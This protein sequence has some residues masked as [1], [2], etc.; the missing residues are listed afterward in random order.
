MS[1]VFRTSPPALHPAI[2]SSP[3]TKGTKGGGVHT[4]RPVRGWGGV[5]IFRKTPDIGLASNSIIPLR[6]KSSSYISEVLFSISTF[7]FQQFLVSFDRGGRGGRPTNG[8]RREKQTFFRIGWFVS[9]VI[10][11][12]YKA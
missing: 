1:G 5:S 2:V 7:L 10:C 12:K 11:T 9:I 3:R 4:H 6:G 8:K